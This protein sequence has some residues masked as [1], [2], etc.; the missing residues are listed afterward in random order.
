[1][2]KLLSL[3]FGLALFASPALSADISLD[4]FLRGNCGTVT[5][6]GNAGTLNNKCGV[7]TTA[8][9]TAPAGS[10]YLVTLTNSAATLGDI[11]LWSVGNG[12]STTG[13]V[14]MGRATV[15]AGSI[16][17]SVRQ[18]TSTNFNGTL[19]ITYFVLKP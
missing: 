13:L 9:L 1:M 8:S 3:A 4:G 2:K 17:F 14:T 19:L 5:E 15:A 6:S 10:E 16:A 12:S 18:A 7:V 11:V